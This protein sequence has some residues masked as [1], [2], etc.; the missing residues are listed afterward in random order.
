MRTPDDIECSYYYEDFHRGRD[1]QEC[2]LIAQTPNG[3][4]W[5]PDLCSQCR[6]PR[7]LMANACPN[8][9]LEARAISRILGLY[10]RAQVTASC[11]RSLEIVNEP[12]IGC[13]Q[14]HLTLPSFDISEEHG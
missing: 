1:V 10:K 11:T 5:T 6:V 4:T 7:I 8:M 12:E 14:C 9:V 2:R 3:G 13:G